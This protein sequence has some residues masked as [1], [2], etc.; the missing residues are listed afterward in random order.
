MERVL[1]VKIEDDIYNNVNLAA[2]ISKQSQRDF[3][4][5][6]LAKVSEAVIAKFK[7]S[8]SQHGSKG[9]RQS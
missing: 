2:S 9:D 7:K 4:S 1:N 8:D 6:A 3:V 5:A